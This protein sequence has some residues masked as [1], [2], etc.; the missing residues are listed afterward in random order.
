MGNQ[1]YEEF[2]NQSIE[3]SNSNGCCSIFQVIDASR[4]AIAST[5]MA[6]KNM[7]PDDVE[8]EALK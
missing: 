3:K 7:L 2:I 6:V 1:N 8:D 5:A 4:I